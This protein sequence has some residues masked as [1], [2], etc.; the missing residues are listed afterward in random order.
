VRFEQ[1][2]TRHS[3]SDNRIVERRR[4]LAA[5]ALTSFRSL[6]RTLRDLRPEVRVIVC[7]SRATHS[8][9]SLLRVPRDLRRG[10][11]RPHGTAPA[12]L[13]SLGSHPL[14]SKPSPSAPRSTSEARTT[15]RHGARAPDLARERSASASR[16]AS[17]G[18]RDC[19]SLARRPLRSKPFRVPRDLRESA[20]GGGWRAGGGRCAGGATLR[21]VVR[22]LCGGEDFLVGGGGR[23]DH[24]VDERDVSA[25]PRVASAASASMRCSCQTL[26]CQPCGFF[27]R[28]RRS[29]RETD[30]GRTSE[31]AHRRSS[32]R[33]DRAGPRARSTCWCRCNNRRSST[34]S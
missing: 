8:V 29:R 5:P 14:R 34:W 31:R 2:F 10:L 9:R 26:T 21:R 27:C 18:S 11:A 3:R 4:R 20:R 32:R 28:A 24:F 17:G 23:C 6:L 19:T 30:R 13:T 12:P 22:L 16:S 1:P 15:A 7:R 33:R 25:V